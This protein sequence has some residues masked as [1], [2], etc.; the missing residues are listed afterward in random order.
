MHINDEWDIFHHTQEK[1]KKT[2]KSHLQIDQVHKQMW[3]TFLES[4]SFLS[5]FIESKWDS[6]W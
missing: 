3:L 6:I 4:S 1:K 2:A 5:S